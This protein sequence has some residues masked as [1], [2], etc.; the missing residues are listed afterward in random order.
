MA[1]SASLPPRRRRRSTPGRQGSPGPARR[2]T[3]RSTSRQGRCARSAPSCR[4]V[5]QR[6][7]SSAMISRWPGASR[8]TVSRITSSS[9]AQVRAGR[10]PA[11]GQVSRGRAALGEH[12]AD[13]AVAVLVQVADGHLQPERVVAAHPLQRRDASPSTVASGV[14]PG[15]P[16]PA[17]CR[18]S[19]SS[20]RRPSPSRVGASSSPC[21]C[22]ASI[23]RLICRRSS[24]GRSWSR[25]A[26]C[27]RPSRG[28]GPGAADDRRPVVVQRRHD[29]ADGEAG[30]AGRGRRRRRGPAAVGRVAPPCTLVSRLL[31]R[32]RGDV[33]PHGQ[34]A[35]AE[36]HAPGPGP[37][38]R[39]AGAV[40]P[41][42]APGAAALN[43]RSS[44][45]V[46]PP[47][48]VFES[49]R[50]GRVSIRAVESGV[51]IR[52]IPVPT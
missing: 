21:T 12:Q 45:I 42:A 44:A 50:F 15:W 20:R 22:C 47:D 13:P 29:H 31:R 37:G 46:T 43:S 34:F 41:S 19:R 23:S 24:P 3:A 4:A 5:R 6:A 17:G 30:A 18:S 32:E 26:G 33:P 27:G 35:D 9:E 28:G 10:L 38:R 40:P 52:T 7:S 25:A 51:R 49:D 14:P 11:H 1:G 48:L 2:S 39:R 36:Q 8:P 16:A